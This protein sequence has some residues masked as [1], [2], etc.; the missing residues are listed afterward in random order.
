M[1]QIYIN[2]ELIKHDENTAISLNLINFDIKDISNR[3]L[4]FTNDFKIP[5]AGN[6][7]VLKHS[8]QPYYY[9]VLPY[10]DFPVKIIAGP[11]VLLENGRGWITSVQDGYYNVTVTEHTTV[12]SRMKTYSLA[13]ERT[14]IFDVTTDP[15][16]KQLINGTGAI[17][18][19]DFIW[20][21][22]QIEYAASNTDYSARYKHHFISKYVKY[23]FNEFATAYGYTFDGDLYTD[24][25]FEDLRVL[26]QAHSYKDNGISGDADRINQLVVSK[27]H[28][29]F[30][31]FKEVLKMFGATFKIDNTT[32][33]IKK[34]DDLDWTSPA[35]WGGKVTRINKK[36]FHIPG[37]FQNNYL[38]Y[39]PEED[40]SE[41]LNQTLLTSSNEN[42]QYEGELIRM[43]AAVYP[44]LNID[45][46]YAWLSD[47]ETGLYINK[48]KTTAVNGA[49]FFTLDVNTYSS[50]GEFI[51]VHDGAT[52]LDA[53]LDVT[54]DFHTGASYP[55]S[56]TTETYQT[57]ADDN[58][59][60]ATYYNSV[61][62][63]IRIADM[64]DYPVYYEVEMHLT[65]I[66]IRTFDP[67]NIVSIPELAGN[68][69]VNAIKNYLL[70]SNKK[71][72]TV[73]LIKVN[74]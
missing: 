74:E 10:T 44:F 58:R 32:I 63:Y 48:S 42:I 45:D 69:Y 14:H 30:D 40:A 60:V 21:D 47:G 24:A 59:T 33:T 36:L 35:D 23:I 20:N 15:L 62:D 65:P 19:L 6:E 16:T 46:V 68:F 56:K 41:T 38:R 50:I 54:I 73:E 9:H 70:S 3:K 11:Y 61:N 26:C 1:I 66:D 55:F 43:N 72:A 52:V 51:F 8:A 4:N 22:Y 29:F 57:I 12:I 13:T 27:K 71:T 37:T 64:I 31:L 17:C 28:S 5:V 34:L 25:Y 39:K 53:G 7:S 49:S 2:N 18:K 67:F